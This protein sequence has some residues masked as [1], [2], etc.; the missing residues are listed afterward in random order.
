[1]K[2]TIPGLPLWM[3]GMLLAPCVAARPQPAPR[4]VHVFVALADNKYQG[5]I[6]VP[7]QL[8]N[9]SD[10][11]RNLYWGAAYGVRT[12]FKGSSDWELIGRVRD[13]IPPS[14]SDASSDIVSRGF[15]SSPMLTK[16]VKFALRLRAF[17]PLPPVMAPKSYP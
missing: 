3:F 13:P 9:G 4:V 1:M 12:F 2:K 6:P 14:S 7:A 10:P 8:G 5:I 17:S 16:A 11:G 15:I